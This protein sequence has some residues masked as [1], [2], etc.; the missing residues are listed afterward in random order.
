LSFI[1]EENW[2]ADSGGN[3]DK[4]EKF[5]TPRYIVEASSGGPKSAIG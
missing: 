3:P 5:G 2:I 4:I 1:A